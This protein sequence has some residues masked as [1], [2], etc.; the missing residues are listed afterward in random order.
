MYPMRL[1]LKAINDELAKRGHT[2]RLGGR[3]LFLFPLRRSWLDTTVRVPKINR[4]TLAE[5]IAEF[6]RL[7]KWNAELFRSTKAARKNEKF[8]RFWPQVLTLSKQASPNRRSL[9]R[10]LTP[11]IRVQLMNR[12]GLIRDDCLHEVT[13]RDNPHKLL[14]PARAGAE[15][16]TASS[17]PL[18]DQ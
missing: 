3:W 10:I 12:V 7:K 11:N 1:T 16:G 13:N 17:H 2:A 15:S 9:R 4:F 6:Q 14:R 5:R 18:L 8:L